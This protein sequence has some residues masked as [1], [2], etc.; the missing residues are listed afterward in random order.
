MVT[1]NGFRVYSVDGYDVSEGRDYYLLGQEGGG[2]EPIWCH[3]CEGGA[4]TAWWVFAPARFYADDTD[5][6]AGLSF[7]NNHKSDLRGPCIW[8]GM[9]PGHQA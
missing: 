5:D 2:C 3:L 9:K 4:N 7:H 8:I 6:G 1:Q